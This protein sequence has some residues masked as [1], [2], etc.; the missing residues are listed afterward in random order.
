M[1]QTWCL[2]TAFESEVEALKKVKQCPNVVN[3]LTSDEVVHNEDVSEGFILL[4]F[5]SSRTLLNI[6]KS[7]C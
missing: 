4:E 7:S 6:I 3:F 2:R 1:P 5:C